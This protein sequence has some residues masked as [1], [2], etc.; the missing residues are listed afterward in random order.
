M[1]SFSIEINGTK[2]DFS[3]SDQDANR[4]LTA[5]TAFYKEGE[6]LPTTTQVVTKLAQEVI[7]GLADRAIRWE[8][9]EAASAAAAAV[10]PIDAQVQS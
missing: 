3:L 9:E 6:T 10:P 7:T 1:A 4:I 2:V 5:F 8:R